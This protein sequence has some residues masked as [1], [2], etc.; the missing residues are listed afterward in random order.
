MTDSR[1][2]PSKK[3]N[4]TPK[5]A[6]SNQMSHMYEEL[7]AAR[8]GTMTDTKAAI[9]AS[10]S[11]WKKAG[12]LALAKRKVLVALQNDTT[13]SFSECKKDTTE[14]FQ[15]VLDDL[16]QQ[17]ESIMHNLE[18]TFRHNV[19]EIAK[20]TAEM[21]KTV[22][23]I[24]GVVEEGKRLLHEEDAFMLW[25]RGF[26]YKN[27]PLDAVPHL[28]LVLK[29]EFPDLT[30]LTIAPHQVALQHRVRVNMARFLAAEMDS[31]MCGN[32]YHNGFRFELKLQLNEAH[33]ACYLCLRAW[34]EVADVRMTV[35]FTL[36]L[37]DGPAVLKT[38]SATHSFQDTHDGWGWRR[39]VRLKKLS[40]CTNVQFMIDFHEFKYDFVT[41]DRAQ[42]MKRDAAGDPL[43]EAPQAADDNADS[44]IGAVIDAD[45][46]ESQHA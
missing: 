2:T 15:A 32:V 27:L 40:D 19:S 37:M 16:K 24:Y 25:G 31:L 35:R 18:A 7:L 3:A 9:R 13:E 30:Q 23:K 12:N 8:F 17:Q 42:S 22:A 20:A 46:H 11:R 36:T 6:I 1:G 26:L 44:L 5:V 41:D 10:L 39:F 38:A 28:N 34:H 29:D 33:L 43:K 14:A 21:D 4:V 45:L